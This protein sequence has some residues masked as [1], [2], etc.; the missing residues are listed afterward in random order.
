MSVRRSRLDYTRADFL[1]AEILGS[2]EQMH[3]DGLA[4]STM[5][6]TAVDLR[7]V[8]AALRAD[9]NA[10]K[11]AIATAVVAVAAAEQIVR[12]LIDMENGQLPSL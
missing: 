5:Y 4:A 1:G 2:L 3:R 11:T 10:L 9:Y 12:Q 8:P 6:S 7:T